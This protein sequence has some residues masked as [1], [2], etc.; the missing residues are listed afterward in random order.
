MNLECVGAG[1][2]TVLTRE[3]LGVIR[4]ADRRCSA[5][6]SAVA[7]DLHIPLSKEDRAWADTE[8]TP[9]MRKSLRAVTIMGIGEGDLPAFSRTDYDV[10]E[11]VDEAQVED[12]AALITEMIRRA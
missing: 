5:L 8:A 11:N 4:R 9:L 6:L 10:P 12:V 1:S 3:G 7:N 2:L